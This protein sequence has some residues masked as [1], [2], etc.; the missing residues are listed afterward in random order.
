[1]I[2]QDLYQKVQEQIATEGHEY[3]VKEFAFT[4]LITCGLCSSGITAQEKLKKLQDGTSAR[5]I[6]Y[7]CTRSRNINCKNGYIREEE[8]INQLMKIIDVVDINELGMRHQLEQEI[9]RYNKFQ[10]K[11]LGK[12]T[13]ISSKVD[14][15][16]I[17]SYAKYMLK[18]GSIVEKRELLGCLYSK[19]ILK[20]KLIYLDKSKQ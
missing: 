3:A 17:R 18:E 10:N 11:V 15:V 5:Y 9:E 20:N 14:E 6:Y 13:R 8:L 2:T 16:E 7:G 1:M 4:K 19:V 12:E